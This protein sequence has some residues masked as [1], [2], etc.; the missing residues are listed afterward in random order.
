M[1]ILGEI[2]IILVG[3]IVAGAVIAFVAFRAGL[4]LGQAIER[5]KVSK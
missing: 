5:R 3:G 4:S 2:G 1:E